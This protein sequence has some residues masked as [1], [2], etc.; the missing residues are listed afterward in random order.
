[1]QQISSYLYPNRL[2]VNADWSS[3]PLEWKIVYQRTVKIFKG[4]DNVLEFEFK[5]S[6]QKPLLMAGKEVTFVATDIE[7]REIVRQLLVPT[8]KTGIMTV[9]IPEEALD[10]L[11]LPQSLKY[12]LTIKTETGLTLPVYADSMFG[13]NGIIFVEQAVAT[14]NKTHIIKFDS[15]NEQ[16]IDIRNSWISDIG[17]IIKSSNF[18]GVVVIESSS[19]PFENTVASRKILKEIPISTD[20]TG[21]GLV[22]DTFDSSATEI[23]NWLTVRVSPSDINTGLV[24]SVTIKL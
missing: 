3:S 4:L 22:I 21:L 12:S 5:N 15:E 20:F 13:T 16:T 24:D 11:L 17:V 6:N 23:T 1:M 8:N 9:T 14:K 19:N 7:G 2:L 10:E 18:D